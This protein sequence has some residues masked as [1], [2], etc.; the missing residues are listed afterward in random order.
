VGAPRINRLKRVT[1]AV[2]ALALLAGVVSA[3]CSVEANAAET[4][5]EELAAQDAGP[6][7]SSRKKIAIVGDSFSAGEGADVYLPGTDNVKN[8]CHRSPHTYLAPVFALPPENNLACSGAIANDLLFPQRNRK[9]SSQIDQ[10][11]RLRDGSGVE[12]VVMTLGGNDA[13]FGTI[14][15][16][17][18][19]RKEQCSNRI[20]ANVLLPTLSGEA[21]DAFVDKRLAPLQ[22]VL[23]AA[24]R[25]VNWVVNSP[26][27]RDRGSRPVPIL[28]LA[29][30][31]LT[32]LTPRRCAPMYHLLWPDEIEFLRELSTR[33]N[34][35]VEAAV[36]TA[37]DEG[38]PVFF[39][40]DTEM[41][42]QPDHTLCDTP[43]YARNIESFDG[44]GEAPEAVSKFG[45]AFWEQLEERDNPT[46]FLR[47]KLAAIGAGINGFKLGVREMVHPN[48]DGYKAMTQA[49][50]RW[51]R[52]P[53][54]KSALEF[55]ESSPPAGS[56]TVATKTSDRDLGQLAP[57]EVPNLRGGTAYP[58][59]LQGF[60]PGSTVSIDVRSE[61]RAL[62]E[63][64]A[65]GSGA[66]AT[67]VG[68]PPDLKSGEHTL[69]I[70]GIEANGESRVVEIPFRI[71]GDG[72][73]PVPAW[74]WVGA[75]LIV[76]LAIGIWLRRRSPAERSA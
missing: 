50:L 20:Y 74:V 22:D 72:S 57:G 39:I 26:E 23:S 3:T 11:T 43:A 37:R 51:S 29:Y 41:S 44:A 8:A 18:L 30:P 58:L 28:V 24:Y 35:T 47:R 16:S 63:V 31:R 12:A 21:T 69:V 9:V 52:G 33:L 25:E 59:T 38:V 15:Q 71:E 6:I 61:L 66:V 48:Q 54:A 42:F 13:G 45:P 19:I 17:C 7:L 60:A 75:A 55:L 64:T 73:S 14:V 62:A 2:V 53:E 4:V 46:A 56:A 49:V 68:I 10:L 27:Q 40:P 36:A 70:A 34:E 5:V 65:N 67:R 32:P 76:L 1:F